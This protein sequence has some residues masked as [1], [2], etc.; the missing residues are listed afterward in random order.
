MKHVMLDLYGCRP[1]LLADEAFLRG[2]LDEVPERIGMQKAGPVGLR[3]IRT[4]NPLDDGYSGFVI[5]NT[6]H[7]SLHAWPSYQMVNIDVFSC[8][9]FDENEVLAF[10]RSAFETDDVEMQVAMRASRSPRPFRPR[11]A[12][13]QS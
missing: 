5:I 7:C 6:S 2:F 11:F 4:S 8:E 13:V 10:A 12:Q 9:D 1:D 3:Y